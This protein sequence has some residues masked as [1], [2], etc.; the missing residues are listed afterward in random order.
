MKTT[1][2]NALLSVLVGVMAMSAIAQQ[3]YFV[4]LRL[5][6][7]EKAFFDQTWKPDDLV[8]VK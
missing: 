6:C 7:P 4:I 3:A 8:K 5:Y 2:K 1:C